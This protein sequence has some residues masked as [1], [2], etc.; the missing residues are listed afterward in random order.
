MASDVP[1][2]RADSGDE[3]KR[4][5]ALVNDYGISEHLQRLLALQLAGGC[6][7]NSSV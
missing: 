4:L 6:T 7:A 3:Y 1:E 5:L 2:T